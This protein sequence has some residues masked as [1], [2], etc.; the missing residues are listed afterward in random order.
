MYDQKQIGFDE[1]QGS[2][3]VQPERRRIPNLGNV[4]RLTR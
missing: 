4:G 1:G 2:V 3:A